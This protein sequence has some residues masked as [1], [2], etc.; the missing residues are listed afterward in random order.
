M[1]RSRSTRNFPLLP[2]K[3]SELL[4]TPTE[5]FWG[6][7]SVPLLVTITLRHRSRRPGVESVRL[8]ICFVLLNSPEKRGL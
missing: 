3:K 4:C 8:L 5:Y 7:F 2:V 6:G 1:V